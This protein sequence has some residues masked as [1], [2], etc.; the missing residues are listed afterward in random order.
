MQTA[1]KTQARQQ[2][3]VAAK[4]DHESS[5]RADGPVLIAPEL[6]Q[7]VSGG[8]GAPVQLATAAA[9]VNKW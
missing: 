7:L 5:P 9:P 8:K 4:V 6:L 2:T 1:H 3:V